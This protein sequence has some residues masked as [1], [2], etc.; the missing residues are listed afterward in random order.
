MGKPQQEEEHGAADDIVFTARK[1][2]KMN[3]AVTLL[4]LFT[5]SGISSQAGATNRV[6]FLTHFI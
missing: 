6:D 1:Q 3:E 2:S 4:S 5:Q